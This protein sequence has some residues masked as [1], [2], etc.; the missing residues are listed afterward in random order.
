MVAQS[1]VD[2][3]YLF[4]LETTRFRG[5]KSIGG[6]IKWGPGDLC[7]D[8]QMTVRFFRGWYWREKSQGVLRSR[9]DARCWN[10]VGSQ[11]LFT[12][13]L[14]PQD[15]CV[16]I[17]SQLQGIW[18]AWLPHNLKEPVLCKYRTHRHRMIS[19]CSLEHSPLTPGATSKFGTSCRK[20]TGP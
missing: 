11:N 17:A 5:R 20:R 15:E 7:G 2:Q 18:A 6:N 13:V 3:G 9:L 16:G 12:M 4:V 19:D 1:R 14:P 10:L 8:P